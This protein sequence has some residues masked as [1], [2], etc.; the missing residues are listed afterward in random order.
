MKFID[1]TGKKFGRLTVIERVENAKYGQIRWL[2]KCDCGGT[3]ISRSYNLKS[4]RAKSC[5]CLSK[6]NLDRKTH[7]M[8]GTRLHAI[9]RAMKRRCYNKNFEQYKD[10]GGRGIT[11]CEEW[12]SDF[13]AFYDWAIANGYKDDLTIDRIDNN[14]NYEPSNCRWATRKEQANNRRKRQYI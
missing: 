11:I 4:G 3:T 8:T 2:C 9:W 13:M 10:Y 7:G 6:E 5:G 12:K 14:G 1:L